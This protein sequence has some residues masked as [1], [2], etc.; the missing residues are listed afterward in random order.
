[1][2]DWHQDM[3]AW[4][5]GALVFLTDNMPLTTFLKYDGTVQWKAHCTGPAAEIDAMREAWRQA[6]AQEQSGDT[7]NIV[8]PGEVGRGGHVG[9]VC[10][11]NTAHIHRG[12]GH[13]LVHS[14][15]EPRRVLFIGFSSKRNVCELEV[16]L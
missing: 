3:P 13:A 14:G 2:Q 15:Q 16:A 8:V 5:L 7:A 11:H 6:L 10:I 4:M 1:M 12:P 9:D